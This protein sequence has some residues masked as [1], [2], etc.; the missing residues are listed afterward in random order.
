MMTVM[1]RGKAAKREQ[2]PQPPPTKPQAAPE[3]DADSASV[4]PMDLQVGDRFSAE[5]FEWEVIDVTEGHLV[6]EEVEQ[7]PSGRGEGVRGSSR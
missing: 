1:A 6:F 5:G 2:K 7:M 3:R 4:L